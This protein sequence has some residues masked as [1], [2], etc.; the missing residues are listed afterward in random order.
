MNSFTAM[1]ED[2]IAKNIPL[3][4]QAKPAQAEQRGMAHHDH[5][6][7]S[8]DF[9]TWM[10]ERC[11]RREGKDDWGGVGALLVDFGEWAD[12]HKSVPCTRPALEA[13][14]RDA[15]FHVVN[16]LVRELVLLA[17]LRS[18]FPDV[19]AEQA[20]VRSELAHRHALQPVSRVDGAL[21]T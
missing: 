19:T 4:E 21:A 7:W 2:W 20:T 1:A 10:K 18:A 14:L 6:A 17:D 9:A 15:G 3:V 12:T 5:E 16:G 8:A 11:A 13:L